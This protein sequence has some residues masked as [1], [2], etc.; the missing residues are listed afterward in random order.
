[1]RLSTFSTE[2][3]QA[4]G[5]A[6][7]SAS[8][9]SHQTVGMRGFCLSI[10][11]ALTTGACVSSGGLL[12][13]KAGADRRGGAGGKKLQEPLDQHLCKAAI[14][15]VARPDWKISRCSRCK[16]E[17]PAF[18]P[19]SRHFVE[20]QMVKSFRRS[21]ISTTSERSRPG[22]PT[23]RSEAQ[24]CAT[25]MASSRLHR[26]R[27][28][29]SSHLTCQSQPTRNRHHQASPPQPSRHPGQREIT[30][31]RSAIPSKEAIGMTRSAENALKD[32][33]RTG[34]A[35]LKATQASQDLGFTKQILRRECRFFQ[36]R[37]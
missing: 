9:A 21:L 10:A 14:Y 5:Y 36:K 35:A 7:A 34:S 6:V 2:D 19:R 15:P 32:R 4:R 12:D 30:T 31:D 29:A 1:M 16:G 11:I 24:P 22:R 33:D 18:K 23:M 28:P 27:S 20:K 37:G 25:A 26:R 8:R 17:V 13:K 3:A